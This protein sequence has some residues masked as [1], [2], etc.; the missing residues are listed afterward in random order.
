[1]NQSASTGTSLGQSVFLDSSVLV[2]LFM[3]WDAC[4]SINK[5]LDAISR[6]Q[7]LRQELTAAGIASDG[8]KAVETVQRGIHAFQTL[9][10]ASGQ[11]QFFTSRVCWAELNHLLWEQHG[12]ENLVRQGLP[13]SL[14][15]KRPQRLFRVAATDHDYFRLED[16]LSKFRES[17]STDYGIRMADVENPAVGMGITDDDIWTGARAFWSRVLMAAFDAYVC[18]AAILSG[19]DTFVSDDDNLRDM[20]K[21]LRD[22]D[23]TWAATAESLM[24]ALGLTNRTDFPHPVSPRARV[25]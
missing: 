4:S 24:S 11:H 12:L 22:P 8:L 15:L 21:R 5:P 19:A 7:E 17:L 3:F 1:M 16:D 25:E 10:A 13:F 6:F 2:S 20:F 9:H 18:A 23:D 14:R